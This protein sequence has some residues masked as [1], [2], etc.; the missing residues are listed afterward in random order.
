[1][2][3]S[4]KKF[5]DYSKCDLIINNHFFITNYSILLGR[6]LWSAY[7]LNNNL[8]SICNSRRYKF[9]LNEILE[10]ENIYQLKPN[11]NIFKNDISR[12]HLCPSYAMSFNKLV[13]KKTY[14]MS[15]IIPQNKY[16]NCNIWTQV[17]LDTYKYIMNNNEDTHIITGAMDIDVWGNYKIWRDNNNDFEYKIPNAFFQCIILNKE[18]KICYIGQNSASSK[19]FKINYDELKLFINELK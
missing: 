1:M 12:G 18:R 7:K 11:A 2:I 4:F 5:I 3:Q 14:Q 10:R 8:L 9:T 19:I 17:E 15:N 6:P 13:S 16:F